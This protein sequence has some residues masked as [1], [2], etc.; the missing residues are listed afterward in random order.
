M[1][2]SYKTE[3][4]SMSN[5]KSPRAA[6]ATSWNS[7]ATRGPTISLSLAHGPW[8][9]DH[10]AVG[11]PKSLGKAPEAAQ[12]AQEHTIRLLLGEGG[13][14]PEEAY[15]TT[16]GRESTCVMTIQVKEQD[17]IE[18]CVLQTAVET[19][20]GQNCNISLTETQLL[21]TSGSLNPESAAL[22]REAKEHGQRNT[23]HPASPN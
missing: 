14:I 13:V 21:E 11:L 18:P 22:G 4:S 6:K 9:G 19:T 1:R 23:R 7:I 16:G 20:R 8:Q 3:F 15:L 10:L 17:L 12:V 2:A 5:Q